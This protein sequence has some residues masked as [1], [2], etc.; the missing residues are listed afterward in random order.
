MTAPQ[1][2]MAYPP[3]MVGAEVASGSGVGVGSSVAVGASG[4]SPL[5]ISVGF[6]SDGCAVGGFLVWT[7]V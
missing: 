5:G 3:S 7:A 2:Q 6:D 1:E 4:C